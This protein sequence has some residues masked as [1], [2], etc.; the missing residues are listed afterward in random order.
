[1]DVNSYLG[2]W[3]LAKV[4]VSL[5]SHRGGPATATSRVA[6][7]VY[8]V[9]HTCKGEPAAPE[10]ANCTPL[11][12]NQP[13]YIGMMGISY[14]PF[15][16]PVT[17][18]NKDAGTLPSANLFMNL[19]SQTPG[20]IITADRL[21]VGL[22]EKNTQDFKTLPMVKAANGTLSP[23][24]CITYA[25]ENGTTT[26]LCGATLLM[27]TGIN[28]FY[29]TMPDKYCPANSINGKAPKGAAFTLSAPDTNNPVLAF[30]FKVDD[31]SSSP[32][33]PAYVNCVTDTRDPSATPS[34]ALF[35]VNTGRMVLAGMDYM[36]RASD[37]PACHVIGFRPTTAKRVASP[38]K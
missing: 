34:S 18:P 24:T 12:D 2:D 16:V 28:H 11:P 30:S 22:N 23:R 38:R 20:Y 8:G 1:V 13:S 25:A 4:E 5:A 14:K 26:P 6:I 35:H 10:Y 19:G 37:N 15:K 7:P 33:M 3:V 21:E 36:Y 17:V 31:P 32:M 29:L 27:D 9:T